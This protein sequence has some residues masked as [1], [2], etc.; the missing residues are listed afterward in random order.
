MKFENNKIISK[1]EFIV[2]IMTLNLKG[3]QSCNK[4]SSHFHNVRF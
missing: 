3:F 2:S 1:K 4:L